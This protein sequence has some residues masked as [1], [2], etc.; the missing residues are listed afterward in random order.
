MSKFSPRHERLPS[1]KLPQ[2]AAKYVTSSYDLYCPSLVKK[3]LREGI[4]KECHSYWPS[5][6]A[7]KRHCKCHSS[8][9]LEEIESDAQNVKDD[10]KQDTLDTKCP[11][12]MPIFK[13]FELLENP[14]FSEDIY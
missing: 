5:A 3:L 12:Q 9:S 10:V 6:A 7:M 13:I 4:G 8:A 14:D 1:V 2:E 11:E